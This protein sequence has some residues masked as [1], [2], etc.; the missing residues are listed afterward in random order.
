MVE[1]FRPPLG[2]S[3]LRKTA[4]GYETK[5]ALLRD[6][7]GTFGRECPEPDCRNYFKLYEDEFLAASGSDLTCPA[8]A[9]TG[10]VDTFGTPDQVRRIEAGQHQAVQAMAHAAIAD[11]LHDMG[12]RTVKGKGVRLTYNTTVSP[13]PPTR[14]LPTYE[15]RAT[16]RTFRCP[17]GHRAVIYDLLAA[18]P[19]CGAD[20]PPRAILDDNLEATLRQLDDAD[21]MPPERVAAGTQT[22]AVEDGLKRVV[23]AIQ[24]LA[25][26]LHARADVEQP[27][28]NPWQNAERLRKQW[29]KSFKVD[30]LKHLDAATVKTLN[31]MFARRHVLEH[32]GG[33][34]DERYVKATGEGMMNRRI[35]IR[36][37][38]VRQA[39][40]ATR[41]LADQLAAT[42]TQGPAPGSEA[43]PGP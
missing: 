42:G 5:I 17:N 9:H 16:V 24:N 29:N 2:M 40:E 43:P 3:P 13:P 1:R 37:S 23:A 22:A 25:K 31:L 4:T 27:G 33:V 21:A 34:V 19:Y 28:D 15:E 18:C 14:P 7:D 36:S 8:C 20:T 26:Q 35:R 30:P 39:I 11:F 32:N 41:A 38:F 12:G 6:E 10:R